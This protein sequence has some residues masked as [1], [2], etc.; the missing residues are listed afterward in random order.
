MADLTLPLR[1]LTALLNG[2][3]AASGWTGGVY[4][5]M[6]REDYDGFHLEVSEC[7]YT[8]GFNPECPPGV[9]YCLP[10]DE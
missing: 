3:R 9:V 7:A 2:Y 10:V 5:V 8:I 6:R 4:F 1:P